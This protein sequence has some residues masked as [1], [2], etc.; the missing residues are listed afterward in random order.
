MNENNQGD[1]HS[2]DALDQEFVVEMN[3]SKE[4]DFTK[5]PSSNERPLT[6]P[7]PDRFGTGPQNASR[8]LTGSIPNSA[9]VPDENDIAPNEFNPLSGEIVNDFPEIDHVDLDP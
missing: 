6:P 3:H 7:T 1:T 2:H 8:P 9:I 5:D 4:K